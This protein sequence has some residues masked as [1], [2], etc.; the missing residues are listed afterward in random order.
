MV[1][2][3]GFIVYAASYDAWG[4]YIADQ[5]VSW[6]GAGVAQGRLSPNTGASTT[7]MPI[8]SG[9]GTI[10]AQYS[11]TITDATGLITV[12]APVLEVTLSDSIEPVEAGGTLTYTIVYRNTGNATA[13]N[14]TLTLNLD[15][16]QSYVSAS[17]PPSSGSGRVRTWN[18]G[19]V[20]AGVS[21]QVLVTTTVTSPLNNGIE[22][23][24]LASLDSYQTDAVTDNERTTVHSQPVL[25]ITKSDM[26]DPVQ[27]GGSIVYTIEFSNTGNMVATGVVITDFIP[28]N[29]TFDSASGN[30]YRNGD[31]VTWN[32]GTLA[33][34]GAPYRTLQARVDSPLPGGTVITNTNYQIDS[35][36]TTP[37]TGPD[38]TTAVL[39]PTLVISQSGNPDPVEVGSVVTFTVVYS[40]TGGGVATQVVITDTVPEHAVF[41]WASG[42]YVLANDQV[43]WNIGT[44]PGHQGGARTV[45]FTVTS[46]LTDSTA[47]INQVSI[48][49]AETEVADYVD[50][51]YVHSEPA[52]HLAKR[53]ASDPVPAGSQLVYTIAYTNTGNANATSVVI[54]DVLSTDTQ[55]LD[56]SDGGIHAR[57]V[58]TWHLGFLAGEGGTGAVVL[59]VTVTSPLTNGTALKNTAFITCAEGNRAQASEETTVTSSPQ[60]HVNVV[61]VPDPVKGEATLVYTVLYSNT[62]NANATGVLLT[63]NYDSLLAFESAD[64]APSS[65]N[66]TWNLPLLPGEGGSGAVVVTLTTPTLAPEAVLSSNFYLDSAQTGAVSH[67]EET[68]ATA[69]DLRL[70]ASYDNNIPY[71]GKQ[72]TY[73]LYYTNAGDIRAEGVVLTAT[74]PNGT[75]YLGQ[76]W[77]SVGGGRYRRTINAVNAGAS[78]SVL[79]IVRVNST[80]DGRLPSGLISLNATFAIAD[81]GGNGPE[82]YISNN[83]ANSSIG[84]PDLVVDEIRATPGSPKPSQPITFTV[85]V[86]NRGTGWGWNP[87]NKTGFYVDLFIDPD[88]VPQSYPWNVWADIYKQT[89][90][91]A[92]GA[93]R[94]IVF[95]LPNGLSGQHHDVYAKVDNWWD[96]NLASWQQNSLVPES[97]EY[98]NVTHISV[99][100]GGSYIFLPVVLRNP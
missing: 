91:L 85:V 16:N 19:L 83:Q 28:A 95:V 72:I 13:T 33:P 66:N 1:V 60:L 15:N 55:F 22:L 6:S 39:S 37:V 59:T 34:G 57:G 49:G 74:C 11:A 65:G 32:V 97:N 87:T 52:L 86:R 50:L 4:N 68:E 73:T 64:P 81:N 56:A 2:Y 8:I 20:G 14:T 35:V 58:I 54:T 7:L 89:T 42:S 98:N 48:D 100:M 44:L 46:P 26:P 36:Q 77:T 45:A 29:T 82:F 61:D 96:P 21:A 9:T 79:F 43:V 3:E 67:L 70:S 94:E 90:A 80:G 93:T 30:Y 41:A 51:V 31:V 53:A 24:S 18:L 47:I 23:E 25:H 62:G 71:P 88:L 78:N 12:R 92:P 63:V 27:A 38:V 99:I 5:T 75:T 40:N 76:G 69:V 17:P 10:E 84:I